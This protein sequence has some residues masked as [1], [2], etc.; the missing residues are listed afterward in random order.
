MEK[1]RF[2]FM[3]FLLSLF[4]QLQGVMRKMAT[5]SRP[6]AKMSETGVC[7][8]TYTCVTSEA[9]SKLESL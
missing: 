1:P 6:L 5:G 8:C 2:E 9:C 4:Q 3:I 7:K